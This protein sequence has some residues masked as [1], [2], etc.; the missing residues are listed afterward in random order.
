MRRS[1]S[2][3]EGSRLQRTER[4]HR[5]VA[6]FVVIGAAQLQFEATTI[7]RTIATNLLIVGALRPPCQWHV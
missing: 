7:P 6:T 5:D 4:G 3:Q 1:G 2:E